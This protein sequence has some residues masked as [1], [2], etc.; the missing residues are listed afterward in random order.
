MSVP[1]ISAL[2][3]GMSFNA[4]TAAFTKNPIKPSFTPCF[5]SK[6]SRYS[7]L[8]CITALMSTSLNVVSIAAVSCAH[9]ACRR[10]AGLSEVFARGGRRRHL[11]DAAAVAV[12]IT[13]ADFLAP[14]RLALKRGGL[15]LWRRWFEWS[16]SRLRR[17]LRRLDRLGLDQRRF[18]LAVALADRA[19]H[20]T[21]RHRIS[22][23]DHDRG[24]NAG[25]RRRHFDRHFV[26]FK[27]DQRLIGSDHVASLLEPLADGSLGHRFAKRWN[28]DL[29]G[30]A[31][32]ISLG[33]R[34][35]SNPKPLREAPLILTGACAQSLQRPRQMPNARRS[36]AA[37][38]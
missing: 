36:G 22:G 37:C 20:G 8:S 29:D 18:H 38:A 6:A 13:V 23:L 27:L 5:F 35:Q 33:Q 15:N 21:H 32:I 25:G 30:H 1:S 19:K 7:R 11:V 4:C 17:R 34:T 31:V 28:A 3:A 12:A 14:H 2:T 10:D 26:G 24:E 9:H 16:W